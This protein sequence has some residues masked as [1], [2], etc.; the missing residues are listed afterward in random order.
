MLT[1]FTGRCFLVKDDSRGNL[2]Q[3]VLTA[4]TYQVLQGRDTIVTIPTDVLEMA[5][6]F[7]L[8]VFTPNL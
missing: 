3:T 6:H 1:D 7:Y 4:V 2:R 5:S 8:P